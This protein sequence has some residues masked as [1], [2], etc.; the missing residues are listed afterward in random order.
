M[1]IISVGFIGGGILGYYGTKKYIPEASSGWK[2]ATMIVL[3][4]IVGAHI[5]SRVRS[6]VAMKKME[7]QIKGNE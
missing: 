3:S 2:L 5:E 1:K 4:A 6:K 7:N